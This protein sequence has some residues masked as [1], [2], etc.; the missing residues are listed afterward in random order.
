MLTNGWRI[1]LLAV[2]GLA[3]YTL[4]AGFAP[5]RV[6][7]V[8]PAATTTVAPPRVVEAPGPETECPE[9]VPVVDEAPV[10][11]DDVSTPGSLDP[12]DPAHDPDRPVDW[13]RA[14]SS[15]VRDRSWAAPS[16]RRIAEEIAAA[17]IRGYYTEFLRCASRFCAVAG[18]VDPGAGFDSCAVGERIA[19]G[20]VFR[21]DLRYSCLDQDRGSR[22]HFIVFVDTAPRT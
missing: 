7:T 9:P 10:P 4:A 20:G 1:T 3:G 6:A 16:E 18:F 22:R 15:D 2:G 13:Y 17:G 5:A 19:E 21:G 8:E 12:W 11:A 14:Y